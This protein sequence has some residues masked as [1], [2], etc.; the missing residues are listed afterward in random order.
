MGQHEGG[1]DKVGEGALEA[2]DGE[3]G[4]GAGGGG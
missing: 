4:G 3:S 2:L 1:T